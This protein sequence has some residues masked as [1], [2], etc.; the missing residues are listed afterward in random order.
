MYSPPSL[1]IKVRRL[2]PYVGVWLP[3]RYAARAARLGQKPPSVNSRWPGGWVASHIYLVG[4]STSRRR[5]CRLC[6]C[7]GKDSISFFAVARWPGGHSYLSSRKIYRLRKPPSVD[8]RWPGG[9]VA[10]HIYLVGKS[11]SQ[12]TNSVCQVARFRQNTRS[13]SHSISLSYVVATA[14][15]LATGFFWRR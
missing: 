3:S 11:T 6:V 1:R 8:S 14:A 10:T 12:K 7:G 4:K 15:T 5:G 13:A 9:Q 2:R